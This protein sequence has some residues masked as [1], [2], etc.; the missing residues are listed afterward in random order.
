MKVKIF[1]AGSVGNHLANACRFMGWDVLVCD[2]DKEA[3]VRMK[4]EIYP[5]RYGKWDEAIKLFTVEEAPK[6]DFDIIIIGT[7]PDSHMD[8]AIDAIKESKPKL[9]LVE[10]PLSTPS[11]ERCQELYDLV[12]DTDIIVCVGYNHILGKNTLEA[13]KILKSGIIG[14]ALTMEAG[15]RE[16]WGG[17]FLAHPWLSG[18]QDSYLGF[19]DRGGGASGEHSHATNLWQHFAHILKKGRIVEVTAVMDI[20]DDDIVKYD[21]VCNLAVRTEKGFMGTIIQDVV[22][23]PTN[24]KLRVQGESGFLEWYVGYQKNKHAVVYAE[25]GKKITEKLLPST[26]PEDF[27]LE[28]KHLEDLIEGKTKKE[29]SPIWIE[30]GLNTML[31][32]AAAHLSNKTKKAVFIDYSKGY[33]KN[34]LTEVG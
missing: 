17:I 18:P 22:T 21:R 28:I 34:S 32:I 27:I 20:I 30:R 26:R 14:N 7:P 6:E 33:T 25:K 5:S 8:L 16:F 12:K 13:E 15:F 24:K 11:L 31:V 2:I 9:M 1:G 3:L 23:E 4:Q 19:F 10:K 29:N